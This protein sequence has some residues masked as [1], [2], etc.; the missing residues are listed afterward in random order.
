[1][2]AVTRPLT[3]W[4]T[5]NDIIGES[6]KGLQVPAL[7]WAGFADTWQLVSNCLPVKP[8]AKIR[9]G[10]SF[11]IV[12]PPPLAGII[13]FLMG[14]QGFAPYNVEAFSSHYHYR[15]TT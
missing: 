4:P 1:M 12:V 2:A 9:F 7:G 13:N 6:V 3:A 11:G 15:F 14:R 8:P 5:R 10:G